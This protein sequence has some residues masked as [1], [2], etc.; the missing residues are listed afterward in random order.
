MENT[1]LSSNF[2][3]ESHDELREFQDMLKLK[4][5][6]FQ[7]DMLKLDQQIKDILD[8]NSIQ[9]SPNKRNMSNV[10]FVDESFNDSTALQNINFQ[11]QN[12]SIESGNENMNISS[13]NIEDL[14]K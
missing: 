10:Q 9:W 4:I 2:Q 13:K 8:K 6:N 1:F 3:F 5:E 7:K 12:V 11:N 14:Y